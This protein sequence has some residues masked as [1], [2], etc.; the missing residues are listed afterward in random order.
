MEAALERFAQRGQL[1]AQ[2]ALGELGERDR[3][4]GGGHE[5]VEHRASGEPEDVGGDA[6]ELDAGVL[7]R[8][9][10]SRRPD[11][12][13]R[14]LPGQPHAARLTTLPFRQREPAGCFKAGSRGGSRLPPAGSVTA[15]TA[16]RRQVGWRKLRRYP[17]RR[18]RL[19]SAEQARLAT[20]VRFVRREHEHFGAHLSVRINRA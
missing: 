19:L 18:P 7:E 3:V 11:R 17:R 6:V 16:P 9:R 10:V 14:R 13:R 8:L 2:P 20:G 12:P 5:R 4:G 1:S 15:A